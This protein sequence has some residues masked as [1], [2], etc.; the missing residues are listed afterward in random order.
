MNTS[1]EMQKIAM[2]EQ[3]DAV[4]M[5]RETLGLNKQML[6]EMREIKNLLE[7]R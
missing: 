5:C 4:V 7:K 2:Q 3:K 1:I 6:S